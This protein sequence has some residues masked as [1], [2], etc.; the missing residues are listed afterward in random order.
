MENSI[1]CDVGWENSH[2]I[3]GLVIDMDLNKNM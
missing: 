3:D 2:N 1:T